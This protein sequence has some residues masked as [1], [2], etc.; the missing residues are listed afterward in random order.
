MALPVVT[1]KSYDYGQYSNPTPVKYM[2]GQEVIGAAIGGALEKGVNAYMSEKQKAKQLIEK[3]EN[4]GVETKVNLSVASE[5]DIARLSAENQTKLRESIEQIANLR[6]LKILNKIGAEDYTSKMLLAN[7]EYEGFRILANV[8]DAADGGE[9]IKEN[10]VQENFGRNAGFNRAVTTSDYSLERDE[11]T[12]DLMI[13]WSD[14]LDPEQKHTAKFTDVMYDS[15]KYLELKPRFNFESGDAFSNLQKAVAIGKSTGDFVDFMDKTVKNKNGNFSAL[16]VDRYE[17]YLA[18]ESVPI[19][20]PYIKAHGQQI[21]ETFIKGQP[22]Y[23][24]LSYSDPKVKQTIRNMVASKVVKFT[25]KVGPQITEKQTGL[26]SDE[27]ETIKKQNIASQRAEYFDNLGYKTK[28][29]TPSSYGPYEPSPGMKPGQTTMVVDLTDKAL[30]NN[31]GKQ[32][33]KMGNP[34]RIGGVVH[35]DLSDQI[36]NNTI[37]ITEQDLTVENFKEII[38]NLVKGVEQTRQTESV[39]TQGLP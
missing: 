27:I 10:Y 26:S 24:N 11:K 35:V 18:S 17:D 28:K 36:T 16:D 32:L 12:N 14:A 9:I 5:K 7:R 4:E 22:G 1:A 15:K 2:G 30:V 21:Y 19:I 34:Y 31:L 13:T 8:A 3:A 25:D 23:E 20:D 29:S 6:K 39:K 33:I 37:T 38:N